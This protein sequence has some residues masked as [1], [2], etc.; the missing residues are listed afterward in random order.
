MT[1]CQYNALMAALSEY[2]KK[3]EKMIICVEYPG[4]NYYLAC[5]SFMLMTVA[6]MNV[7]DAYDAA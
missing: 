3:L 2:E 7:V 1:S 4:Y 5:G 6:F